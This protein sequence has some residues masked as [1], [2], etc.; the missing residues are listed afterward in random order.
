MALR[1]SNG[2]SLYDV[3]KVETISGRPLEVIGGVTYTDVTRD[4][5]G[6]QRVANPYT[7]FD[8][9]YRYFENSD[10]VTTSGTGGSKSFDADAS[11]VELK[12]TTASGSIATRQTT[13]TFV[14][15]PGKS[16]LFLSSIIFGDRIE[17]CVKQ[18]G[19]YNDNNGFF[20][21]QDSL[22]EPA[23]VKRSSS[24]GS[25]VN[26]KVSQSSWNVDKL[27]G[28][29]ESGITLDLTKVQ[30]LW[31]D[32]EWLGSGTVR[33]GFIIGG[34]YIL[35]HVFE[36][37]N[38]IDT[39][40]MTTA[41]LPIQ[42]KIENTGTATTTGSL[43]Q[44]CCSVISEGGYVLEGHHS[45]INTPISTPTDLPATGVYYPLISLRLKS[46]NLDAA[47]ILDNI[48][49]LGI[50]N[51]ANYNIQLI[52]NG[53]T[54]G[55]SWVSAGSDSSVEYNITATGFTKGNGTVLVDDYAIG[56]AQGS[57][58]LNLNRSSLFKYQLERDGLNSTA[59]EMTLIAAT[60]N[61]GADV[62]GSIGWQEV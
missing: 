49:A 55:G 9:K 22:N 30:I 62:H 58:P 36:H 51:N 47:I 61:A 42:F 56:S 1:F 4:S 41:T 14:Y 35:C 45:A 6:R 43:K 2:R 21:E 31:F 13:K 39:T 34:V 8:S 29:G 59:Y 44:I 16:L 17:N 38:V 10:Y 52:Q 24:S 5:F 50:T 18:A 26:T 7:L 54:S 27:D 40:Y 32:F 12:T 53:I 20:L 48:A 60:D 46:A 57:T 37:A 11:L 33:C 19:Y 3:T 28:T 25:V 15:Q 23:F